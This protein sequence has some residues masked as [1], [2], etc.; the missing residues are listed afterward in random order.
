M[1][2]SSK[3]KKKQQKS[4]VYQPSLFDKRRGGQPGNTNAVKHGLYSRRFD[5][6]EI[7]ALSGMQ[8]GVKD[9]IDVVRVQLSRILDYI[10]QFR[11][12]DQIKMDPEDYAAMLNLITKNASTVARLMQIDK[13]LND[14]AN[15]GIQEQLLAAL[16]EVNESLSLQ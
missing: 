16:E 13:A 2:K 4:G 7:E 9:E 5:P 8:E 15:I 11:V 14:A 1:S 12:N 3:R 6:D 10:E